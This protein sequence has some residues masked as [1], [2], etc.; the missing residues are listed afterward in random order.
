MSL[1][2]LEGIDLSE[3]KSIRLAG[4]EYFIPPLVFRQTVKIGPVTPRIVGAINRR[5]E[6]YEKARKHKNVDNMALAEAGTLS[7]EEME[8]AIKVI[9]TGL[10]RA[11]PFVK[12]DDLYEMSITAEEV[13]FALMVVI[14][15][16][17]LVRPVQPGE[18]PSGEA[19]AAS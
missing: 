5:A 4:N 15:Q 14:N 17:R 6:A 19:A 13:V 7:E 2:L 16:A 18:Q 11:Y 9:C 1:T 8:I 3:A 12:L 10:S